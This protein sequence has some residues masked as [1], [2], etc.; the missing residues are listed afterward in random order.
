M[1]KSEVCAECGG[2]AGLE[3]LHNRPCRWLDGPC[4]HGRQRRKCEICELILSEEKLAA[5][6]AREALWREYV[7]LLNGELQETIGLAFVHGW[8]SSRVEEGER[9]RALLNLSGGPG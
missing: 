2:E 7:E 5:L 6:E 9:L 3:G 4:E 1:S 8:R